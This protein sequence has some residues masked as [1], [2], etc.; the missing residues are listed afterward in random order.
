[1]ADVVRKAL[2][3]QQ[4]PCDIQVVHLKGQRTHQRV[5]ARYI[6]L[7]KFL[8]HL[9]YVMQTYLRKLFVSQVL[10]FHWSAVK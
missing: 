4:S 3:K 2:K 6:I 8:Y 5:V 1:M 9:L 10:N 7:Y